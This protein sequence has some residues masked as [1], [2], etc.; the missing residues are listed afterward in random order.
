MKK[1][2]PLLL[3]FAL[4]L[5]ACSSSSPAEPI[6]SSKP[7]QEVQENASQDE[8]SFTDY[9]NEY[10]ITMA[11]SDYTTMHHFFEHP[12]NYGIDSKKVEVTLGTILPTQEDLDTEKELYD[13]LKTFDR[14]EL[15]PIQ[16]DIYDQLDYEFELNARGNAEKF[17]YTGNVW[18]TMSGVQQSLVNFFSEYELREESDIEPLITLLNDVPHYTQLALDYSKKQAEAGTLMLDYD[19]VIESIQTVLDAKNDSAV[20]N[21]LFIEVENLNL[22]KEKEEQYKKAIQ[23]AMDQSFFPAYET[24][25]SGLTELKEKIQEPA[26]LASIPNGKEYYE[27]IVQ[28]ATGS[29][30]S[31]ET[32]RSNMEQEV[33]T[34]QDKLSLI[35]DENPKLLFQGMMLSTDFDSVEE[36]MSFL[37]QNYPQSFPKLETM[38]YDLQALADDQSQEGIVAYFMQP[39]VDSTAKYQIRYNKRDYGDDPT[40]LSLYQTLAHEGIPGHMYQAQYNKEHFQYTI[41]YFLSNSGFSEGYATYVENQ[42]LKFLD[43]NKQALNIS[44]YNDLLS[45]YYVILMD[46]AINYD[47]IDLESF[48]KEFPLFNEE[49]LEAI[50]AQLADNPGVFLSYY[51][52]YYLISQLRNQAKTEM[53]D[54]FDDIEFNNALLESGSVNF[55]IVKKNIQD[56]IEKKSS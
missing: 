40:S 48:K 36:I 24:M 18:S 34:I 29:Q 16:Q 10:V 19:A 5:T 17:D 20:T 8:S 38:E 13:R 37:Q 9:L 35:L 46:I 2:L 7:V 39:A 21:E 30:D 25:K 31:I 51:Y 32:I 55:E 14:E 50:Y 33:N 11:E 3:S 6:P 47:G 1:K 4:L 23:E 41:Q 28:E 56:Y 44:S 52:G 12:E 22:S 26:G 53:G 43:L 42:A 54:S 15:S 45:N 49:G 27:L